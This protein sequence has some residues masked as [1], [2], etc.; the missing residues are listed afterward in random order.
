LIN[1]PRS[2]TVVAREAATLVRLDSIRFQRLV[3]QHPFFATHVMKVLADRVR[4]KDKS[5]A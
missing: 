3:Q 4:Q 1:P 5:L 2:A